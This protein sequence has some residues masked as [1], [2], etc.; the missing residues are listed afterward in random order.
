MLCRTLEA[1]PCRTASRC[2][3]SSQSV[4]LLCSAMEH[5]PTEPYQLCPIHSGC[6]VAATITTSLGSRVLS[7]PSQAPTAWL[8]SALLSFVSCCQASHGGSQSTG[9][10]M[11][12]TNM[13]MIQPGKTG[14]HLF[15]PPYHLA[16]TPTHPVLQSNNPTPDI[17]CHMTDNTWV[18]NLYK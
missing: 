14:W 4:Q 6:C 5:G 2:V 16:D 17:S 15:F 13:L 1:C 11:S 3:D 10:R 7:V 9:A 8:Q 18:Q 12:S